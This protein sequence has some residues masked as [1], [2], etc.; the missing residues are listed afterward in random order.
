[1]DSA[2]PSKLEIDRAYDL[3]VLAALGPTLGL[4]SQAALRAQLREMTVHRRAICFTLTTPVYRRMTANDDSHAVATV[5]ACL[6]V[7]PVLA[8]E[9]LE[10]VL[11]IVAHAAEAAGEP[12]HELAA[13]MREAEPARAG[14]YREAVYVEGDTSI[15]ITTHT[16]PRLPS[17]VMQAVAG[18]IRETPIDAVTTVAIAPVDPGAA[19]LVRRAAAPRATLH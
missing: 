19:T 12:I 18:L 10:A 9:G 3:R 1:M 2:R 5:L 15:T 6:H 13:P 17:E 14:F 8:G 4:F 7:A 16:P 11:K